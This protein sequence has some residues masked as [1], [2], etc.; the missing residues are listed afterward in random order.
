MRAVVW[1]RGEA[2]SP[3][4]V[5]AALRRLPPALGLRRTPAF[6]AGKHTLAIPMLETSRGMYFEL[7]V[8][9]ARP[10]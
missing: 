7:P 5:T 3:E 6:D 10:D 8:A 2:A 9:V 4:Q 1:L